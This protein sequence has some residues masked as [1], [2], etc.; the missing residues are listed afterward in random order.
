MALNVALFVNVIYK[1]SSRCLQTHFINFFFFFHQATGEYAFFGTDK[2]DKNKLDIVTDRKVVELSLLAAQVA[3]QMALR[4][5]HDHIIKLDVTKY[6]DVISEHVSNIITGV[7]LLK[8]DKVML[9]VIC[10]VFA[11]RYKKTRTSF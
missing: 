1:E 8:A 7:N 2:D 6:S 3:G 11:M 9:F 4:L 5:V 10:I